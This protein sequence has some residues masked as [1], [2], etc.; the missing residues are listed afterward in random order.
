M[1]RIIAFA[2]AVLFIFS[3]KE[4]HVH[5]PGEHIEAE[6]LVILDENDS[7]KVKIFRGIIDKS[8]GE[9]LIAVINS[10]SNPLRIKFLNN[11]QHIIEPPTAPEYKLVWEISDPSI[12]EIQLYE[13][14][15]NKFKFTTTGLK[16]GESSVEFKLL[17]NDHTDF[18]SGSIPLETTD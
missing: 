9:K 1:S 15:N 16:I 11:L 3:C 7:V 18:R 8:Y 13:K 14:D 4:D 6:G 5:E 17:H 12:A 2:F 10:T